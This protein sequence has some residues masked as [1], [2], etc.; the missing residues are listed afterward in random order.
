[1]RRQEACRILLL[2]QEWR[3]ADAQKGRSGPEIINS[4]NIDEAL[5]VAIEFLSRYPTTVS[6]ELGGEKPH[7]VIPSHIVQFDE[8]L[9]LAREETAANDAALTVLKS[10]I[11]MCRACSED[12]EYDETRMTLYNGDQM[13]LMFNLGAEWQAGKDFEGI[14]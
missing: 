13:T 7:F 1:M 9:N 6:E 14:I 12:G 8:T 2:Y 11:P 3:K 4:R 5:D 10:V